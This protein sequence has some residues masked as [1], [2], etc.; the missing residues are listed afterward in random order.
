MKEHIR[1][2][3][4]CIFLLITSLILLS[5]IG[6]GASKYDMS[7]LLET[8]K[9]EP[10]NLSSIVDECKNKFKFNDLQTLCFINLFVKNIGNVKYKEVA[11]Q[12]F[13]N[14]AE[15]ENNIVFYKD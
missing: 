4:I 10:V 2:K 11:K 15:A 7:F 12:W 13:V 8:I 3:F 9:Y 1:K 14:P 5:C 6:V